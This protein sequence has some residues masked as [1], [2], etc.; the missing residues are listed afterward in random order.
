MVTLSTIAG[1]LDKTHKIYSECTKILTKISINGIN[2][3]NEC[4]ER[5]LRWSIKI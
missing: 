4:T 3:Y 2:V 5:Q 1:L